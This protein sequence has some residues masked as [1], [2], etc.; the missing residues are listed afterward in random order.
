[1]TR[2]RDTAA[3][4]MPLPAGGIGIMAL[5]AT[6]SVLVRSLVLG[7][8]VAGN[9]A[10]LAHLVPA[11]AS[12]LPNLRAALPAWTGTRLT[13]TT[14]RRD[15]AGVIRESADLLAQF[16]AVRPAQIDLVRVAI[17]SEGNR[18][19]SFDLTLVR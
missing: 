12:P 9:A 3:G 8:D 7:N 18:L 10:A 4:A 15:P 11:L 1:L 6:E 13:P 2:S 5:V 14:A 19:C 17:K 16:L